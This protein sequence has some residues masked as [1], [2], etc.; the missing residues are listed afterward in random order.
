MQVTN[1]GITVKDSPQNT[2]VFVTRLDDAE[3]VA[4]ARV[5]IRTP[6]NAVFWTGV[7]GR[8]TASRWRPRTALRDPERVL[9]VPL[10]RH[11]GEGRRR[12]LRRQRLER[13]H[14]ALGVRHRPTTSHEA[15][16]LLRGTVFSDRGVYKLGEEVHFKAILRSDTAEGMR[17]LAGGTALE[18]VVRDSQGE[19]RGQADAAA[20]GVE[21]RGLDVS[22]LPDGGA[23]RHV[24]GDGRRSRAQSAR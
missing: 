3:P 5:S 11:G 17:L 7:T 18:I 10:P 23:A 1:L 20:L 24:R 22:T 16:P 15:Q 21:Q 2:L 14:R 12:R 6:D 19:E 13:G 8:G 9:G 4:G